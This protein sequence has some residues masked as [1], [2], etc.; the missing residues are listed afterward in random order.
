MVDEALYIYLQRKVTL[1]HRLVLFLF[2][3]AL[4]NITKHES[5]FKFLLKMLNKWDSLNMEIP[6]LI[7]VTLLLQANTNLMDNHFWTEC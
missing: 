5:Q 3:N 1:F 7:E 4:Y 6:F 2:G